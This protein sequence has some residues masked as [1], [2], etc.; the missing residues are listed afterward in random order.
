MAESG[1]LLNRCTTLKLYP[2]FESLPHRQF[3]PSTILQA[4]T[5]SR[6]TNGLAGRVTF[7]ELAEREFNDAARYYRI[8]PPG[9]GD[10]F[11]TDVTRWTDAN[12]SHPAA[13]SIIAG[14]TRR[15]CQ[16]VPALGV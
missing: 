2:G 14:T 11:I 12:H 15:L 3:L 5:S 4:P 8:E 10:A 9:L 13:G 6:T 16:R 1:G 7:N